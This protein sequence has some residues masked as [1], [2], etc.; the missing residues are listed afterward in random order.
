MVKLAVASVQLVLE[1]LGLI[2]ALV[3]IKSY[4]D[5]KSKALISW[6]KEIEWLRMKVSAQGEK[7]KSL[8]L[9]FEK[10]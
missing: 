5:F 2:F 4:I 1:V 9:K 10:L 7:N 8:S 6:V 3:L